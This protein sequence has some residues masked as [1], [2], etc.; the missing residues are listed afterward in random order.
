MTRFTNNTK[1]MT[2]IL[3]IIVVTLTFP[4]IYIGNQIIEAQ[5]KISDLETQITYL[6]NM[7]DTL[8]IQER[9]LTNQI[10]QFQNSTDNVSLTIVS[11][12]PWHGDPLTGYPFYKFINL[13]LQNNGVRNIGG[14][15]LDSRV[16]GNT[17]NLGHLGIYVN[18]NQ[19]VLHPNELMNRTMQLIA[20]T[21]AATQVLKN[22]QLTIT[23][24]LD[25]IVL[26]K[27]TIT[28]GD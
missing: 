18:S 1:L 9:N 2:L 15:I 27:K 26:D 4:T 7:S 28:L 8:Q 12:G 24:T 13:T 25:K 23:L 10:S 5:K 14:M 20:P 22:Y 6:Q 17:S 21:Q 16:E 3:I 11:I 19:G